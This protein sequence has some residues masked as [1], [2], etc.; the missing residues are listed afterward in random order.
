VLAAT[1]DRSI[2]PFQEFR[3]GVAAR[4][5]TAPLATRGPPHAGFLETVGC[6]CPDPVSHGRPD[7]HLGGQGF[8]IFISPYGA[9]TG[10]SNG[11][12]GV[13]PPILVGL[14][15]VITCK[16]ATIFS[17]SCTQGELVSN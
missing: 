6:G 2:R 16:L 9:V 10:G 13:P 5:V 3:S 11:C 12:L 7:P 15:L 4:D 17:M 1:T 8:C 14:L